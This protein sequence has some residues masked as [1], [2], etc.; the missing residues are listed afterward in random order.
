MPVCDTCGNEYDKAFSVT[1]YNGRTYRFDSVECMAH[2]IAPTCD[3]CGVRILGHGLEA[4]GSVY[5]CD[6]CSEKQG[7]V[8]L[9]DRVGAGERT[10][11]S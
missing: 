1:T 2:K 5:C 9:V 4:D 7:V 10:D 6:H 11:G 8:G 3:T